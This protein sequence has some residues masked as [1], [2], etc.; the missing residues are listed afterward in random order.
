M[1]AKSNKS[2]NKALIYTV[3]ALVGIMVTLFALKQFGVIGD[4]NSEIEVETA[5]TKYANITQ[6]V[7]A[8]GNIQP[9][10]EVINHLHG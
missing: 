4:S 6:K 9:E 8:S 3:F 10:I 2:S 1:S 5:Y 7:S